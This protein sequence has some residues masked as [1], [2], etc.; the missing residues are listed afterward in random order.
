MDIVIGGR[1]ITLDEVDRL[2]LEMEVFDV[3][4]WLENFVRSRV[5]S[6]M[7]RALQEH[8]IYNPLRLPDDQKR[9]I[10]LQLRA[11]GKIKTLKEKVEEEQVEP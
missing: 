1:K 10:L 8:S 11:E 2:A 3:E 9:Q 7:H 4:E 5:R 6:A